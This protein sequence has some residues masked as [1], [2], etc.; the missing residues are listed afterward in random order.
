MS[1]TQ[2]IT[3]TLDTHRIALDVDREQEP[4]YRKAQELLNTEYQKYRRNLPSATSE[5]LWMYV[6]LHVAVNLFASTREHD[7]EP[8]LRAIK[9][10]NKEIEKKLNIQNS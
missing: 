7:L 4:F 10:I 2:H 9:N 1:D 8:Y 5:Q 6:A 3:L